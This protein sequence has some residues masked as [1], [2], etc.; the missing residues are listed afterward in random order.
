MFGNDWVPM[1]QGVFY[2]NLQ[3]KPFTTL[4]IRLLRQAAIL[5]EFW[6][7]SEKI[8]NFRK[9]KTAIKYVWKNL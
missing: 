4:K 1:T 7:F 5:L 8:Q 2:N 9:V 6:E 3:R